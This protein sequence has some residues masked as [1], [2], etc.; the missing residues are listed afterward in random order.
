MYHTIERTMTASERKRLLDCRPLAPPP[1]RSRQFRLTLVA[2][3]F[4]V[5][6]AVIFLLYFKKQSAIFAIPAA[7]GFYALWWLFHLK[8][9]IL[10]PRRRWREANQ[11]VLAFHDAVTSAQSVRVRCVEAEAVVQVTYDE[12]TI[13]LFDVG[14]SQTYWIDLYCMIPGRPPK[15]WPNRKFEVVEVPGWKGEVGPFCEGK[16]LRPRQTFEFHDLFEHY[17]FEPPPDGLIGQALDA[18]ITE[19]K[20]RNQKVGVP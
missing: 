2:E 5:V 9:R 18:F 14:Q 16:R 10:T 8:S 12:G 11:R 3:L 4:G 1:F 13:C 19:A 20:S 7:L 15:D 6:V 17:E